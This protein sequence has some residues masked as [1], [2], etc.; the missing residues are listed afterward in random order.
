[1]QEN[2]AKGRGTAMLLAV[3][4]GSAFLG[5]FN[6]NLMNMALV[7]VMGE[8]GVGSVTVQWL[9][10][11]YMIASTVVVTTMAYFYRRFKLRNL[12][13]CGL[14]M[15]FVGSAVGLVAPNFAV[16]LVARLVQAVGT[17]IFIPM[18]FNTVVAVA[19]RNRLGTF[20]SIG[21]CMISCAPAFAPV[22]CGAVVTLFGWRSVFAIPAAASVVLALLGVVFVRNLS[23]EDAHLDVPSVALSAVVLFTLSYG[24]AEITISVVPAVVSLAVAVASAALFVVR[25]LRCD[26]PLIDLSPVRRISY[27][28]TLILQFVAMM[29]QF[30][31]SVLLPLYFEGALGMTALVAGLVILVP[32][33]GNTV[34]TL[35]GGRVMDRMGEWPLLP[36]GFA[37]MVGGFAWV[38][39]AAPALSLAG[40]VGGSFLAFV[41]VGLVFSP[42]QSAGLRG[43]PARESTFAVSLNSTFVQIAAC[44]GPALFTGVM[45]GVQ[46]ASDAAGASA[47]LACAQGFAS[48]VTVAAGIAVVGFAVAVLYA[49]PAAQRVRS[50]EAARIAEAERQADGAPRPLP[51]LS[52]VME[53]EPYTL[54]A[55]AP[56]REA[57]RAFAEHK[58]SGLPLVDE[59]GRGV[60]FVSDGD[61][62]RYLSEQHPLVTNAYSLIAMG[63]QG[64]FDSRLRE[65]IDLPVEAVA[66]KSLVSASVD[67]G[68]DEV[69]ELLARRQLKKV[70]VERDGV[71]VGTVNRSNIIRFAMESLVD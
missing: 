65:L 50:Q 12:L 27:W 55:G 32:V 64:S 18:M 34:F 70:P 47:A 4:Y 56:V 49:R 62:M 10:T 7:S 24:L 43:L 5:G 57:M 11:G 2:Q 52:D 38:V 36:A 58:V 35:A 54:P 31:M 39:L 15:S 17:G 51:S 68:L 14:G 8:F 60:G 13:F 3:M 9:V 19:P 23:N 67:D 33:L 61:V 42:S 37:V 6:E 46:E 40:M 22:A 26:N 21:S 66:T 16:L 29:S 30:S 48:S 53:S 71:V 41:G 45:S 25:Q 20:M 44:L 69:C 1:M 28:P 59:A 63:D